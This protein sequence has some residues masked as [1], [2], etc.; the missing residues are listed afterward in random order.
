MLHRNHDRRLAKLEKLLTPDRRIPIYVEH[1]NDLGTRID[2]L[3]AAG[4]L[5]EADRP[6]CVFWLDY[7]HYNKWQV[8]DGAVRRLRA[9]AAI[10]TPC[11]SWLTAPE[12]R[13][14]PVKENPANDPR[15]NGP[16]TGGC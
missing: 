8:E 3:I 14:E 10:R 15:E 4:A 16:T 6:R 9:Q 11:A 1:E 2:E 5:S 13:A 12:T 7:R